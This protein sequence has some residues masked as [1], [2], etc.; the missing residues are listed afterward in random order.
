MLKFIEKTVNGTTPSSKVDKGQVR[1]NVSC[2]PY[3]LT[4]WLSN[5]LPGTIEIWYML[6]LKIL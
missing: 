4:E 1:Y 5:C 3:Y 2:W 6:F